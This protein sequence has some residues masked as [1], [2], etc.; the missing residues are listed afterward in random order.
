MALYL[1]MFANGNGHL[2]SVK[3][4]DQTHTDWRIKRDGKYLEDK[5]VCI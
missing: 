1:E 2:A 3:E 4:S 5:A